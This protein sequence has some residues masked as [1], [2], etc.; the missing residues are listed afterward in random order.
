MIRRS[1]WNGN[2]R[3]RALIGEQGYDMGQEWTEYAALVA[4]HDVPTPP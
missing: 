1:C 4:K 3:P 2:C